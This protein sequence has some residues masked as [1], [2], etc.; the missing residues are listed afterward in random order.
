V[1]EKCNLQHLFF[2]SLK[3]IYYFGDVSAA[4]FPSDREHDF[5]SR[6]NHYKQ[7]AK[8]LAS[9]EREQPDA[10]KQ[11]TSI[12]Y[13]IPIKALPPSWSKWPPWAQPNLLRFPTSHPRE[14]RSLKP[15]ISAYLNGNN[16][17]Q[18]HQAIKEHNGAMPCTTKL[19]LTPW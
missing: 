12:F 2:W 6:I 17:L 18:W 15:H 9:W 10:W 8:L 1:G 7:K 4:Q 16:P 11:G 13:F 14:L 3:A 5:H 19:D